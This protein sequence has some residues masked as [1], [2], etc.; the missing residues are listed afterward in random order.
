MSCQPE[1]AVWGEILINLGK[2]GH[3]HIGKRAAFFAKHMVMGVECGVVVE[4]PVVADD[5]NDLAVLDHAVGAEGFS[6]K[7]VLRGGAAAR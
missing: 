4:R 6:V 1:I 5:T 2:N 3:I 7:A